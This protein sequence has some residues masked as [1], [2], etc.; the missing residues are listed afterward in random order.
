[1][2]RPQPPP[3]GK[4]A[5]PVRSVNRFEARP[6]GRRSGPRWLVLRLRTQLEMR[7]SL[8]ASSP[9]DQTHRHQNGAGNPKSTRV[10]VIIAAFDMARWSLLE[11]AVNS[12]LRQAPRPQV[13]VAI[14]NNEELYH[15]AAAAF[16]QVSV[17]L[18][19]RERGASVTRL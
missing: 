7:C 6:G 16:E 2:C 17:V 14:D 19:R 10:S 11:R 18:N 5:G 4:T 3:Y 9:S 13:V 15:R 12:A 1:M 8:T